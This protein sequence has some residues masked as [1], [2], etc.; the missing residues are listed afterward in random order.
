MRWRLASRASARPTRPTSS[1]R[2]WPRS[3]S[4]WRS[5]LIARS[6]TRRGRGPAGRPRARVEN[7]VTPDEVVALQSRWSH[8]ST[9]G[10]A[11]RGRRIDRGSRRA[12]AVA[13]RAARDGHGARVATRRR[14][15]ARRASRPDRDPVRGAA[16]GQADADQIEALATRLEAAPNEAESLATA[17]AQLGAD[18]RDDVADDG[19][20]TGL[21]SSSSGSRPSLDAR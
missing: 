5:S 4:A 13:R 21:E 17:V 10:G 6:P 1:E 20:A 19:A 11:G 15:R 18:R 14:S 7:I 3:R 8:S 12:G 16:R 2:R 9:A